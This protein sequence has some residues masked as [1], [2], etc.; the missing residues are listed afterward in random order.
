MIYIPII[1]AYTNRN[2]L[3][4]SIISLLSMIKSTKTQFFQVLVCFYTYVFDLTKF[5]SV[6][7]S[8][9]YLCNS[10]QTWHIQNA[11]YS[12]TLESLKMVNNFQSF[13]NIVHYHI[14]HMH[15]SHTPIWIVFQSKNFLLFLYLFLF[16]SSV[17]WL[18]WKL[19]CC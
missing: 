19:S 14:I 17:I 16:I 4:W 2:F 11:K 18:Q 7:H 5:R 1:F 13:T 12:K 15:G 10:N 3:L 8:T 6:L 9:I